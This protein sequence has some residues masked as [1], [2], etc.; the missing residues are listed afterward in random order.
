M[1]ELTIYTDGGSRGNPGIA[2]V[3]AVAYDQTGKKVEEIAN[4]IGQATNN[5]AEYKAVIQILEK[6]EAKYSDSSLEVRSDSQLL[7]KQLTG[8]YRVKNKRL[9]KLYDRINKLVEGFAGVD[10]VHI[11]REENKEA[12]RL[13]NIAMDRRGKENWEPEKIIEELLAAQKKVNLAAKYQDLIAEL[14]V[15]DDDVENEASFKQGIHYGILLA[16]KFEADL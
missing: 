5:V 6:L 11:P 8:E 4:Y 7:V 10:F 14:L 15:Q 3:G 13:A 1:T 16:N 12:D 2:G 9:K